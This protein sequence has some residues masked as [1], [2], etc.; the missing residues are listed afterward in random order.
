MESL[1]NVSVHALDYVA[2][3]RR[4]WVVALS[5]F[6]IVLASA[7]Y[8]TW[9]LPP[10]YQAWTKVTFQPTAAS[11]ALPEHSSPY[12]KVLLQN[13][14]FQTQ[15]H[16]ISSTPVVRRIAEQLDFLLENMTP[17]EEDNA[18]EMVRNAI[19]VDR[20]AD[21]SILQISAVHKDPET[22]ARIADIAAQIYVDINQE[23]EIEAQKRSTTW[24]AETLI[25][26]TEKLRDSEEAWFNFARDNDLPVSSGLDARSEQAA[27]IK[28]SQLSKLRAEVSMREEKLIDLRRK[29]RPQHPLVASLERELG[30]LRRELGKKEKKVLSSN[31]RTIELGALQNQAEVNRG[32]RDM[33]VRRATEVHLTRGVTDSSIQIIEAAKVPK[34]PIRPNKPRNLALAFLGALLFAVTCAFFT[35]YM[36]QSFKTADD[37]ERALGLPTLATLRRL[38][39]SK[40]ETE[41]PFLLENEK[42]FARESEAFRTLRTSL[43][44]AYA[45]EDRRLLLITSAG[46]SEGKTTVA[47]NL[48]FAIARTNQRVL[49]VDTDFRKPS[50]HRA[51]RLSRRVGLA[52]ALAADVTLDEAIAKDIV[53]NLDVLPR[54]SKPPNPSEILDS[55][56]MH[57]VLGILRESYDFVI[58]D[59]PPIGTVVDASV[60]ASQAE[61]IVLV[62]EAGRFPAKYLMRVKRRIDR[63]GARL[64]GV[65]LN[66]IR[67]SASSYGDYY[68]YYS[69]YSYYD[70]DENEAEELDSSAGENKA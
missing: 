54:G 2:V 46:P 25:D 18:V 51:F 47:I 33:L 32:I 58:L 13:L 61:G 3:L 41:V 19:R 53:P 68:Y 66:K 38:R 26:V 7:S 55:E 44:F 16:I 10:V 27:S 29:Y 62:I 36:D 5:V 52:D 65:V 57:E 35:D 67:A 9:K 50:L 37:V 21:S 70:S 14:S 17:N 69:Y 23:R 34:K 43:R 11:L 45:G 15:A 31:H 6:V 56:R 63:V 8:V 28:T 59:S 24:L 4:R 39:S 1:G 60:L 40:N 42:T 64:Y 48:A 12:E 30:R 49:L 20:I 22:A